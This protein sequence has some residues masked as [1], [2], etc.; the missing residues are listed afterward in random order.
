MTHDKSHTAV[1]WRE[2]ST[3][4][5]DLAS[6]VANRFGANLHHVLGTIRADGSPRLSGTEVEITSEHLKLGMMPEARKRSD[7]DNDPRVEVHSA[8]IEDKLGSGDAKVSGVLRPLD[9]AGDISSFAVFITNVSLVRV[10]HDELVFDIWSP[11]RGITERR[12]Q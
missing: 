8:P 7:V 3:A 12:R 6:R 11:S 1:P 10:D 2:F 5:P 9:E 4:A